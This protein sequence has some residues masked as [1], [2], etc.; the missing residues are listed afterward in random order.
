MQRV[1]LAGVVVDLLDLQDALDRVTERASHV[2]GPGTANPPPLSVVSANMDHIIQFGHGGRWDSVLGDSRTPSPVLRCRDDEESGSTAPRINW[3]TLLD[4]AP[5]VTRANRITGRRWPRLAGSDLIGPILDAAERNGSSV[6][7]L[8]GSTHVQQQLALDLPTVR[9]TLRISGFWA[10]ERAQIENR[11]AS[12]ELAEQVRRAG[13]DILVVGLGKPRQELWVASYGDLTGARVLLSFGA[14]VDFLAG[15]VQRAPDWVSGHGMEWAWRLGLEPKRLAR[16]YLL[17]DPP[18]LLMIR[19]D[20]HLLDAAAGTAAGVEPCRVPAAEEP[21]HAPGMFVPDGQVSSVSVLAVTYNNADS[22]EELIQSLRIEAQEFALRL[23]VCDNGS[24]DATL[25]V[26]RGHPDV[27]VVAN[28]ANL[29]YAGGI[30]MAR[31]FAGECEAVLVLNPDLTVAPGAIGAL[32]KRMRRSGAGL[33]VPRLLEPDGETYRSLRREPSLGRALGDA[34]FGSKLP[35]RPGWMSEIEFNPESYA[36]PHRVD[37]AT[38]AALMI[39]VDVERQLGAWD[40]QFFLYSEETDY[41]RRARKHGH[42]IWYEPSAAMTHQM[43]GSGSSTDLN[44][45]MAVN[46]VRYARKH[47]TARYAA[48]FHGLVALHHAVRFNL[49]AHQGLLARIANES[50]WDQLPAG[51]QPEDGGDRFP[52]GA[53]VIPAHN[54]AAVI[55][56]TLTPLAPLAQA[57]LIE[58]VVACNGCTDNT[59]QIARSFPG[60]RVIESEVPSKVAALNLAD[61]LTETFPRLYLDADII[62]TV[63]ALRMT[64]DYLSSP[65]ALSARPAFDYDVTG[66]AWPVRAFYRARRRIPSSNQALWGAGAYGVSLA[67][68]RRFD[69]FPDVTADDLFVDRQFAP[70]EKTVLPS[71]PVRVKTPRTVEA[72][73]AILRRTYRGQGELSEGRHQHSTRRTL[74]ELLASVSGPRTALDVFV[75]ATLASVARVQNRTKANSRGKAWERDD[76]S[77]S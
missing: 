24:G 28:N 6:G 72:L 69:E 59:A 5:L 3:L 30:N 58:V 45:L 76:T 9:P 32:L 10:P 33:V 46:R 48:A 12:L 56:R 42:D 26:L 2:P 37:W 77:R 41:F 22:I 38:G 16:R 4:G 53:V 51:T 31:T 14:V 25:E 36:H 74:R 35:S 34:V 49:P 67:G 64:F 75:Y 62:I 65:Q 40:E 43:G 27:I 20:S 60:I 7:F 50:T 11:A 52:R 73:L 23:V 55:A 19:R 66:A 8:G 29:G 1:E 70:T 13:T 54:E 21:K 15:T 61:R 17:D 57:G 63:S 71:I 39:R 68:R 44:A 18:G 47:G